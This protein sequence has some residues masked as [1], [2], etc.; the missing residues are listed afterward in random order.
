MLI[1]YLVLFQYP[2]TFNILKMLFDL[3]YV[4]CISTHTYVYI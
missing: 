4:I 3:R 2:V 1:L